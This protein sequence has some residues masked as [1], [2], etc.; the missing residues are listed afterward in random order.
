MGTGIMKRIILL[1]CVNY[2]DA[3]YTIAVYIHCI[4]V[5]VYVMLKIHNRNF[6]RINED[7]NI[8]IHAK[9]Y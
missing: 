7:V 5:F 6:E 8:R 2:T 4:I 3:T 9:S 1:Q